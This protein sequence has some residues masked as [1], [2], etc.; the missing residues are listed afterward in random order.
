MPRVSPATQPPQALPSPR[1]AEAAHRYINQA[2]PSD[3]DH[4]DSG[5]AGPGLTQLQAAVA[6]AVVDLFGFGDGWCFAST[7]RIIA[8]VKCSRSAA[9]KALVGLAARG[10]LARE[11]RM[12]PRV[13]CAVSHYRL[14]P[15]PA[16]IVTD[17]EVDAHVDHDRA[18]VASQKARQ[19]AR[20]TGN[21][22]SNPTEHVHPPGTWTPPNVHPP[23]GA[24][25]DPDPDRDLAEKPWRDRRYDPTDPG[26]FHVLDGVRLPRVLHEPCDLLWPRVDRIVATVAPQLGQASW[27]LTLLAHEYRLDI[28]EVA[29]ALKTAA[30]EHWDD[31]TPQ[32]LG[33]AIEHCGR[34]SYGRSQA[35]ARWIKAN[36]V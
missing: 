36:D 24:D 11:V 3:R 29:H 6:H 20:K 26:T 23:G 5:S 13:N 18:R 17:D 14:T 21:H 22:V 27:V 9:E 33:D 4:Q 28:R 25:T 31:L 19:R 1:T 8:I 16:D 32:R 7:A 34:L 35:I 15:V 2:R 30:S 10:W 12:L